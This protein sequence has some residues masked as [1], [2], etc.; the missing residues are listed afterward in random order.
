[1]GCKEQ[2]PMYL[3]HGYR[4]AA[5]LG[6]GGILSREAKWKE[7]RLLGYTSL[8]GTLPPVLTPY[9]HSNTSSEHTS[10]IHYVRIKAYHATLSLNKHR[11]K[12]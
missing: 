10:S 8:Q 2:R 4:S 11:I 1:M 12:L 3:R 7:I 5:L 9:S 6:V